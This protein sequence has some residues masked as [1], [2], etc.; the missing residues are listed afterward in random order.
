MNSS[1]FLAHPLICGEE[2]KLAD[3]SPRVEKGEG[4]R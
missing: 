1:A 3:E 4:M 2:E